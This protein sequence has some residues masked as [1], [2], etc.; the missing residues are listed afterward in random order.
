MTDILPVK[1]PLPIPRP[2]MEDLPL[3]SVNPG[4]H[5]DIPFPEMADIDLSFPLVGT[6]WMLHNWNN[7]KQGWLEFVF[8]PITEYLFFFS[9]LAIIGAVA[10][11]LELLLRKVW[12]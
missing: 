3:G 6:N 1:I 5:L 12:R 4:I 2:E 11:G 9:T 7:W 8:Y 10:G